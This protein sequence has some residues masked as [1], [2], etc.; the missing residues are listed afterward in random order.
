MN[1]IKDLYSFLK[2]IFLQKRFNTEISVELVKD[3]AKEEVKNFFIRYVC[4]ATSGLMTL[5]GKKICNSDKH[6]KMNYLSNYFEQIS[7]L[8]DIWVLKNKD[9]IIAL[10]LVFPE[11]KLPNLLYLM[12]DRNYRRKNLGL[13]LV[14]EILK[15]YGSIYEKVEIQKSEL[16]NFYEKLGFVYIGKENTAGMEYLLFEYRNEFS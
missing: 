10:A 13:T 1:M 2:R 15:Y 11:S 8:N 9:T 3:K 5:D 16:R 4:D 6:E 14:K 12:V 7:P